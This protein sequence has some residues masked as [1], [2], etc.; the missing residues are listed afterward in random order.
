[1]LVGSD[2]CFAGSVTTSTIGGVTPGEGYTVQKRDIPN[3]DQLQLQFGTPSNA[4]GIGIVS[5]AGVTTGDITVTDN[6]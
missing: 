4:Y 5:P 6:A 2:G 3:A 1:M